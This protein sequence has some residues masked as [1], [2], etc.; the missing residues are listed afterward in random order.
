MKRKKVFVENNVLK[1]KKGNMDLVSQMDFVFSF[2]R[3]D[4][5]VNTLDWDVFGILTTKS[6]HN[7]QIGCVSF[8][9]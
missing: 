3:F 2:N 9:G 1:N 5:S 6:E 4:N 7:G 8:S